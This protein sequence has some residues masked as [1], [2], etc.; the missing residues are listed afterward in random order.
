M[1]VGACIARC[2]R[3]STRRARSDADK[4]HWTSARSP[5]TLLPTVIAGPQQ[6]AAAAPRIHEL[7]TEAT[8]AKGQQG[9]KETKKEAKLTLKEKRAAKA[10]KKAMKG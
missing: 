6:V 7:S 9:K 3:A 4:Y 2:A 8:M 5:R 1:F 10:A